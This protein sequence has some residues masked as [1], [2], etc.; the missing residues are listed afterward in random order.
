MKLSFTID[1]IR[2]KPNLNNNQISI[3][4]QKSFFYGLLEFRES[5]FGVLGDVPGFVQL[6]PCTYKS[7]KPIS[8][9]GNDKFHLKCD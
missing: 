6:I 1:N 9:T 8:I 4:T 5:P 3:F 7:E 2:L